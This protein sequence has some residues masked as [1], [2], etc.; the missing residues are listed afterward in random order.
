MLLTVAGL[1]RATAPDDG[2]RAVLS[3]QRA[4]WNRGDLE[5]FM[6]GYWNDANVVF[7]SGGRV[8][9]GWE[10]ALEAYQAHYGS[11]KTSMGHLEFSD[12]EIHFL[13][14]DAAWVLGNWRLTGGEADSSGVFTLVFRRIDGNWKIVMDH[15]S[16]TRPELAKEEGG[17]QP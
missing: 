4:A 5:A 6:R 16:A 17:S 9:R 12:L 3:A 11:S 8:R 14:A 10:A 7:T 1:A 13:A 2:I 15:S